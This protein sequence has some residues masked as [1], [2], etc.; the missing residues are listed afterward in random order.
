MR[1][2]LLAGAALAALIATP[3]AAQVTVSVGPPGYLGGYYGGHWGYGQS[4]GY[5]PG[6]WGS[7]TGELVKP[8]YAWGPTYQ[9]RSGHAAYI[10]NPVQRRYP[11]YTYNWIW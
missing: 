3:A 8:G 7:S 6:G 4:Y 1:N 9:T 2:V 11:T 10:E 5:G